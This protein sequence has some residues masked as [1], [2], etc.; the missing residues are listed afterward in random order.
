MSFGVGHRHSL[1]LA[2]LWL[3]YRLA[4]PQLSPSLGNFYMR[5]GQKKKNGEKKKKEKE[6]KR[7]KK[8]ITNLQLASFGSGRKELTK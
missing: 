6:R 2:L 1:D 8:A 7:K 3:W 5:W 4:V